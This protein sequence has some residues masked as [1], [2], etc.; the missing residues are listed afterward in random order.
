MALWQVEQDDHQ[1]EGDEE[2]DGREFDPCDA[3]G[4]HVLLPIMFFEGDAESLQVG[5]ERVHFGFVFERFVHAVNV[6]LGVRFAQFDFG[7]DTRLGENLT[8]RKSVV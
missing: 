5:N 2:Y 8:D 7:A 4:C 6:R 1:D 3:A